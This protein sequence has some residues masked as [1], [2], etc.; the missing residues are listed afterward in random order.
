MYIKKN[1]KVLSLLIVPVMVILIV[2][3]AVVYADNTYSIDLERNSSQYLSR[4]DTSGLAVGGNV[5]LEAW[6]KIESELGVSGVYTIVEVDDG[7]TSP[8]VQWGLDYSNSGGTKSLRF[9]RGRMCV[10]NNYTSYV[11]NLNVDQWYHVAGTY[12]GSSARL[13]LDGSLVA[14]PTAQSGNGDSGGCGG[15]FTGIGSNVGTTN[16]FDG[17]IDDVRLWNVERSA[18]EILANMETEIDSATNLVASWHLNNALTDSSGNGRTLTNNNSAVFSTDPGFDLTAPVISSLQSSNITDTSAVITWTTDESANSKVN[19][20][21]ASGSLTLS[22]STTPL[23]T[24]HSMALTGLQTGTT[25][26]YRAVS[27]DGHGNIATS[28]EQSFTTLQNALSFAY[29]PQDQTTSSDST[30]SVDNDLS[31]IT[32]DAN[33]SY[34]ITAVIIASST[35][36]TPDINT[37]FNTPPGSTMALSFGSFDGSTNVADAGIYLDNSTEVSTNIPA[38]KLVVIKV[39]GVVIT[40]STPG[41]IEFEWAQNTSNAIPIKVFKGSYLRAEKME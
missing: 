4:T 22:A 19:Y 5:T 30:L 34:V 24:T 9:N 3:G 23:V 35:S 36:A 31:S 15:D 25:Y 16:Y 33:T 26:Y 38:N 1:K 28:S 12:D 7:D 8:W 13:Y 17:L 10:N 32:L 18:S 14:G 37:S 11:V 27:S 39:D 41:T 29:K 40:S 2:V 20:G 21:T 6:F